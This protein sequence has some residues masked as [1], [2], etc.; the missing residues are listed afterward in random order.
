[1]VE[2]AEGAS[3]ES[4]SGRASGKGAELAQLR[5]FCHLEMTPENRMGLPGKG[6][7]SILENAAAGCGTSGSRP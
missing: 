2:K 5:F 6:W 4:Y 3:L 1:M 7:V